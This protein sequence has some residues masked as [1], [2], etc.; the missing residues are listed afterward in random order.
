[1]SET[2][3]TY[4]T[5]V[6]GLWQPRHVLHEGEQRLGTLTMQR[7]RMG[8]VTGGTWRPEAGEVF[9]FRREPGLLRPQFSVWTDAREWLASSDRSSLFRR[10]LDLWTGGKPYRLVPLSGLRRGWRLIASRTGEALRIE[11]GLLRRAATIR[12]Y[13]K[14]ELELVLFSYFLGALALFQSLPPTS[15]DDLA[16]VDQEPARAPRAG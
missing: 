13:R 10:R 1:M 7:N 9:H 4:R 6:S 8:M 11:H 14:T 16:E 5:E 3:T 12:V 15:L 2:L